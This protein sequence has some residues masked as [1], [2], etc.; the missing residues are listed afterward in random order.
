MPK[1]YTYEFFQ[2]IFMKKKNEKKE[3]P[4]EALIRTAREE[5][6]NQQEQ[7]NEA[8]KDEGEGDEIKPTLKFMTLFDIETSEYFSVDETAQY[9]AVGMVNGGTVVYDM[10]LGIEK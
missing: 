6:D 2:Q 9:L 7:E 1:D 5:I 8:N 4:L 10:N 3:N